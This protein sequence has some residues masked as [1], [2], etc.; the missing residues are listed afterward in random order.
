[1][2]TRE[3][4][5]QRSA[6][7]AG[8]ALTAVLGFALAVRVLAFLPFLGVHEP[9]GDEGYYLAMAQSLLEGKGHP[10][11]FRPPLY[12]AFISLV[13]SAFGPSQLALRM[14]QMAVSLVPVAV[15]FALARARFGTRA[16]VVS[17]LACGLVP[18]LAHYA[19]FLWSEC[20]ATA[21][22]MG[23]FYA[24]DRFDR[25]G[26]LGWLAAAGLA[27][28]AAALVRE[29]WALFA[30]LLAAVSC[31]AGPGPWR[32]RVGRALLLAGAAYLVILP[33][34]VRNYRVHGELVL[35]S[36]CRWF[37]M[38]I[39]NL[40]TDEEESASDRTR[41]HQK[42]VARMSET[43]AERYWR[44]VA[45][46]AIAEQQPTWLLDKTLRNVP[47]MFSLR[48]QPIR[49]LRNEWMPRPSAPVAYALVL[50]DALGFV[51]VTGLGLY[52]LW[53][54]PGGRTRLAAILAIVFTLGIHVAAN[55]TARFLVPLM[56][57][58]AL[59]VG[60]ALTGA[61]R[62]APRW[63][64]LAGLVTALVFLLVAGSGWRAVSRALEPF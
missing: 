38:A 34:T 14:V 27:L 61:G 25:S 60:P 57:L 12:P 44:E 42:A 13:R 49:Y 4:R 35:V 29:T 18:S 52:A 33:W 24:W 32:A 21:V 51:L 9:H 23:F 45:L 8:V 37:P 16:A 62:T 28:G 63:R 22:L 31:F 43:D 6:P 5:P 17:G 1:V 11:S 47:K 40:S 48:S 10:G 26:R 19:H 46:K 53:V 39:G 58:F 56:P 54:V 30:V 7:S 64:K 20:L 59:Y 50:Y 3:E 15:V 2:S 55:A 36:T 41:A